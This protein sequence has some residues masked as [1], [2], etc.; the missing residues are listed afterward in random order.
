[1]EED[2][3][4]A[5]GIRQAYPLVGQPSEFGDNSEKSPFGW[6]CCPQQVL[7]YQRSVSDRDRDRNPARKPTIDEVHVRIE[8]EGESS[9]IEVVPCAV[10]LEP[11][12]NDHLL[13]F[14]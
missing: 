10:S 1:M 14:Y 13:S 4:A 5:V 12:S 2:N 3:A 9:G 8:E 7:Q 6:S 11:V